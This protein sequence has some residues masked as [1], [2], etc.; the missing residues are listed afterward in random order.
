[1]GMNGFAFLN[2]KS[3]IN[4]V[5]GRE[6]SPLENGHHHEEAMVL[7]MYGRPVINSFDMYKAA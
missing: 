1:M 6:A 7:V 3:W 4:I 2:L 5:N